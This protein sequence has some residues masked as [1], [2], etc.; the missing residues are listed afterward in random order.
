[1]QDAR[2]TAPARI[3]HWLIALALFFSFSLGLSMADMPISPKRLQLFSYHKWTGVTIFALVTLRLLWRLFHRP[4]PLPAAMP[5][6]E[7]AAAEL[8]HLLLYVLLFAMP[9]TGWLMSS[10]KGFQT[11][12]LGLYPIPDLIAKNPPL[13]DTLEAVHK[14]LGCIFLTVI[15]VHAA[16][17]LKHHFIDRDDVLARMLPGVKPLRPK[18]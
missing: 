18:T 10:A 17:A 3:F 15:G 16:A 13:G 1:M 7:K 2:Y 6:W 9:L 8:S 11:V 4:P 12:Y 14:L 5:P